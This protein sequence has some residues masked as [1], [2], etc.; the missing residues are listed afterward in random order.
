MY[1]TWLFLSLGCLE[2]DTGYAILAFQQEVD[3]ACVYSETSGG[4]SVPVG[5]G[6]CS[7]LDAFVS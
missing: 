7:C 1:A 3:L 5:P 6:V 4:K 2:L